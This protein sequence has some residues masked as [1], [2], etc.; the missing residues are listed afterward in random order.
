[1]TKSI[2]NFITVIKLMA[3][4]KPIHFYSIGSLIACLFLDI[5]IFKE[6]A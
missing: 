5:G 6:D 1:M 4:A 3:E 2:S